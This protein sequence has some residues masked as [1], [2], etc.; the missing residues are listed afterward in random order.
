[1]GTDDHWLQNIADISELTRTAIEKVSSA[2]G[3]VY[4]PTHIRRIAEAHADAMRILAQ[5]EVDATDIRMRAALRVSV[6]QVRHQQAMEDVIRKALPHLVPTAE[7]AKVTDDWLIHFFGLA[8]DITNEEMRQT[9]GRLLAGE[10][11]NPGGFSRRTL[12]LVAQMDQREAQLFNTLCCFA[13]RDGQE[14]VYPLIFDVDA[15]IYANAGLTYAGLSDLDGL[16]LINFQHIAGFSLRQQPRQIGVLYQDRALMLEF[17]RDITTTLPIGKV[18]LTAPGRQM[19]AVCDVLPVDGF[20][21]YLKEAWTKHR[22]AVSIAGAA[23]TAT[24]TTLTGSTG[25]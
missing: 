12:N 25:P 8:R 21:E 11:N 15:P 16:G 19:A 20:P 3:M 14:R 23:A 18:L 13:I 9:W 5:G 17:R 7:P 10:F 24:V 22:I 6:E 2:T 1:M 4:E